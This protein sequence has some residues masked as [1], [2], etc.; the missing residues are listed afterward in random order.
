MVGRADERTDE[1]TDGL[2][3]GWTDIR[4]DGRTDERT[5]RRT[6]G[7][8][9]RDASNLL[10]YAFLSLAYPPPRFGVLHIFEEGVG[11]VGG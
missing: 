10:L 3:D 1:R 11:W 9:Y 8:S 5:D 4:T 6:D 7:P 2:T